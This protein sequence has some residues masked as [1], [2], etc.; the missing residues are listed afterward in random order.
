MEE[1][2]HLLSK[3]NAT[4]SL[5]VEQGDEKKVS[6]SH[7]NNSLHETSIYEKTR[8]YKYITLSLMTVDL[9]ISVIILATNPFFYGEDQII[10]S[11]FRRSRSA[12]GW[13]Y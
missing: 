1:R 7:C 10:S 11:H 12:C 13:R 2:S 9:A 3:T 5:D 4:S 6:V 8:I